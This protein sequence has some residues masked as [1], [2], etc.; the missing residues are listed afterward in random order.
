[1]VSYGLTQFSGQ[2]W[3]VIVGKVSQNP[4]L[5]FCHSHIFSVIPLVK[6]VIFSIFQRLRFDDSAA[7]EDCPA[8][9]HE[10][11]PPLSTHRRLLLHSSGTRSLTSLR[12]STTPFG[13]K[14]AKVEGGL[15]QGGSRV[16]PLEGLEYAMDNPNVSRKRQRYIF[17]SKIS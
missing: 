13:S 6:T 3:F 5:L 15:G 1:M 2:W 8:G 7:F 17:Q 9:G 16:D 10:T 11:R 4:P 12:Q 14:M